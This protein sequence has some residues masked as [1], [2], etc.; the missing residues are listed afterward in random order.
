MFRT[1]SRIHRLATEFVAS[2]PLVVAGGCA[3]L[4]GY[5][6][7][8]DD[9]RG[10]LAQ[11]DRYYADDVLREFY[12]HR[13]GDPISQR[14]WR[15]EV[16]HARLRAIDLHYTQFL[17]RA[18]SRRITANAAADIALLGLGAAGT[19]VPAAGDKAILAAISGGLVG[20]RGVIDREVFYEKTLPV[21]VQAMDAQRTRQLVK[22]RAGLTASPHEY[23]LL[24]ALADV[25]A[26]YQAGT[27]P[28]AI[29]ALN[30]MTSAEACAAD[31]E[32]NATRLAN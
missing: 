27:F 10:E 21:L 1:R 11:L 25:E 28:G 24:L 7:R 32:L 26:Y 8:Q 15:D 31:A 29:I 17:Q 16:V 4:D 20:A 13:A 30:Q 5:P 19:L 3:S 6:A 9:L 22:I 2:L 12:V 18:A 23:P 14:A